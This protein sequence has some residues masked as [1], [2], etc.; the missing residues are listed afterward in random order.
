MRQ[1][2]WQGTRTSQS[3]GVALVAWRIVFR[4]KL[5]SGLGIRH[6]I[7]TNT[8]LLGKWVNHIMQQSE[9]LAVVVI[10]DSYSTAIDWATWS[11]PCR[12]DSTFMQGLRLVFTSVQPLLRPRVGDGANFS[13]WEADWSGHGRF[14]A[15]HPRLYALALD[16]RASMRTVWDAGWFPSLPSTL[17]DQQYA[18]LFAL[19]TALAP[20]QLS[21]RA[22]NVWE[23]RSGLSSVYRCFQDLE[24]TPD[25]S[26]LLKCCCLLWKCRIPLKI[27]LFSWLLL[28]QTLMT[29]SLRQRF[30]PDA[31]TE[32][33]LC[34]GT[35]EDCSHLFFEC[36]FAQMAWRATH[37]CGL[38]M[39]T[40][41]SFWRSISVGPFRRA[42]E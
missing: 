35:A 27:K 41:D 30:C 40:A 42:S 18:D 22:P 24:S 38:D 15:T 20:I 6:L 13:F 32:C 26:M 3:R 29:R 17:S 25:S 36:H 2:F 19:H 37:M 21:E 39:S 10:R 33:P 4:P 11:T 31:P 8:A 28:R 9:D 23:W 34:A 5:L 16:S 14:Q 12:G 7:H 1:F